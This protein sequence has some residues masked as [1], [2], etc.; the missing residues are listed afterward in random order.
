MSEVTYCTTLAS[1]IG[2]LTLSG[3]GEALTGL[4]FSTGT[5]A[6]GPDPA[7]R[8]DP[9]AFTHVVAQLQEY[10]DGARQVFDLELRPQGT[11]FQRSVWQALL[12]IPYGETRSYGDIAQ[13]IGKP[14]AVRAVGTANGANPIALIIPCHR[15]IGA[16]GSLTGFGGGLPTK[17]YLLGLEADQTGLFAASR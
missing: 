4:H 13:Q 1:P 10:F 7:W 15:V 14:N 12:T 9:R 16:D 6:R 2:D 17:E 8:L 5:K 11:E 3:D